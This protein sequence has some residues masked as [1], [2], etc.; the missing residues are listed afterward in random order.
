[1]LDVVL[2]GLAW[3][4]TPHAL[5]P[6][7]RSEL[8]RATR[9]GLPRRADEVPSRHPTPAPIG[10]SPIMPAAGREGGRHAAADLEHAHAVEREH[11]RQGGI[12]AGRRSS[13]PPRP[14]DASVRI[15]RTAVE[16]GALLGRLAPARG[17]G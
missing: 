10:A 11:G 17:L 5:T 9:R 2:L 12:R 16:T 7:F 1:V 8:A 13:R 14:A 3:L 4:A 6:R 15:A